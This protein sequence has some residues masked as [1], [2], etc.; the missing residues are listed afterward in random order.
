MPDDFTPP[1]QQTP[2]RWA[3]QNQ[4]APP[5]PGAS[6]TAQAPSGYYPPPGYGYAP[7]PMVA[8]GQ[9]AS[10]SGPVGRIRP[11][12][13]CILLF[14]V[15]L[16]IYGLVWFF[17]VHDEMRRH[18]AQGLG[19]VLALVIALIF[20]IAMPFLTSNEV[21][22]LEE[23]IGRPARVTALTG[24]WYFPGIFILVGPIVWF[25]KTNGALNDYW[26]SAGAVG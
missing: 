12:G 3:P 7:A 18:T 24:L 11:T 21:G 6:P 4:P 2:E 16:G 26:R 8:P 14:V 9:Y 13:M 15:T 25:V 5:P 19:G 23:R 17:M 10:P 20:H 1:P 22:D